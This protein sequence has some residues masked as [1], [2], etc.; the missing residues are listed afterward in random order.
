M[1]ICQAVLLNLP[2]M[3][4]GGLQGG[5]GLNIGFLLGVVR[6]RRVRRRRMRGLKGRRE[7][8]STAGPGL[9]VGR[10]TSEG[11]PGGMDGRGR[12]NRN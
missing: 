8:R 5:L 11:R 6:R 1:C 2:I 10:G 3:L 12:S 9:V 7:G 4:R